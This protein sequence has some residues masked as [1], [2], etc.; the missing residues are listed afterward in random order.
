[1]K[2]PD[3]IVIQFQISRQIKDM[4]LELAFLYILWVLWKLGYV[5]L[6]CVWEDLLPLDILS[7]L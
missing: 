3:K 2:E 5:A 6:C 1:M 7:G 4:Y